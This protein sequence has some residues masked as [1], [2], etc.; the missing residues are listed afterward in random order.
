MKF[1]DSIESINEVKYNDIAEI[2]AKTSL[3]ELTEEEKIYIKK[4]KKKE[5]KARSHLTD[6]M[7]YTIVALLFV[8]FYTFYESTFFLIIRLLATCGGYNVAKLARGAVKEYINSSESMQ[9]LFENLQISEQN[10]ENILLDDDLTTYDSLDMSGNNVSAQEIDITNSIGDSQLPGSLE[11]QHL[12]N[13]VIDENVNSVTFV[14]NFGGINFRIQTNAN[15]NINHEEIN[16]NS[17]DEQTV[18]IR[19]I[20]KLKH[21]VEKALMRQFN[22]IVKLMIIPDLLMI[23]YRILFPLKY[24]DFNVR[25]GY[26]FIDII[27]DYKKYPSFMNNNVWVLNIYNLMFEVIL[28]CLHMILFQLICIENPNMNHLSKKVILA[29][30]RCKAIMDYAKSKNIVLKDKEIEAHSKPL[31]A[32]ETEPFKYLF[33]YS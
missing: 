29:Q 4:Y 20:R 12:D 25:R 23:S 18:R 5:L 30:H 22:K 1:F 14:S 32:V 7:Y 6:Q 24:D 15:F 17:T 2:A 19:S 13:P 10:T 16:R 33:K 3:D 11:A 8:K 28:F 27:S 21:L 9:R 31:V 26:A